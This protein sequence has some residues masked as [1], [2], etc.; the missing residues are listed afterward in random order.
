MN[1]FFLF[2]GSNQSGAYFG[3]MDSVDL[4][5]KLIRF[6]T[7]SSTSSA[8]G[9][10]VACANFI[11]SELEL[12]TRGSAEFSCYLLPEAPASSPVVVGKYAGSDP[13]LPCVL[14]NCHYDV[15][16]ADAADWTQA[17]PFSGTMKDGRVY[18]RGAQDMK[19]VVAQYISAIRRLPVQNKRTIYLTFVPDEEIGGAGMACFLDSTLFKEEIGGKDNIAIALD[20]GLASESDVFS[21]FYGE[22]LPWWVEISSKGNTGHGSRFIENTAIEQLID[23]S[24]KALAFRSDQKAILHGTNEY[25]D[26]SNCAHSVARKKL[27]DVTS[28][29]ITTLKAGVPNGDGSYCKNVVPPAASMT[30]DIRISPKVE[31]KA[32][33]D[34]LTGWCKECSK[35]EG[36]AWSFIGHGNDFAGHS[37]TPIDST[38]PWYQH[39]VDGV[40]LSG[41]DVVP[42]VF[43]AATD[44]RFLRAIGVRALGFSPMRNSEILLHENDENIKVDVFLE[45]VEV[46]VKLIS[47]LANS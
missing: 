13:T 15:V 12:I 40:K 26:H 44:S 8:T 18:G 3:H 6:R 45:G 10:Y 43:P 16:P 9:E 21:V 33:G 24:N 34:M 32:I 42:E 31:P 30:L 11:L 39:F 36:L 7:I 17:E 28:L 22:R 23:L 2:L 37:T 5:R 19:C 46:Y 20:E 47:H 4:L 35:N 38:N 25:A 29:N 27:G 14:L 1:I 41:I